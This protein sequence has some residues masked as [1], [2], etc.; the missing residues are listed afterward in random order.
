MKNTAFLFF[1]MIVVVSASA[2][3][4]TPQEVWIPMR[5][6]DSLAADLHAPQPEQP[7]PTILVQTPYNKYYFRFNLP[8]GYGTDIDECPYNFVIMDWR[9]FYASSEASNPDATRG[10]DGYDAIDWIK[11]QPWSD[12]NIGT[13]GAS[14]LGK[15][16]FMTANE[17]HPNHICAV[18]IVASPEYN[19]HVYYPNGVYRDEYMEQLD[20]LGFGISAWIDAHPYHDWLWT[21]VE[22]S[23]YAPEEIQ[24]PMLMI[25]GWYDHATEWVIRYF[26]GI[27]SQSPPGI[28]DQHK[29]MMG[30]WAHNTI[31]KLS[32]GELDFPAAE[33]LSEQYAQAFF[34]YHLLNAYNGWPYNPVVKYFQ[35]GDM[36]W[37]DTES[38][39]PSDF[40][41]DTFYLHGDGS[42]SANTLAAEDSCS[43]FSYD[44]RD[45]SPTI[46]GPTLHTDLQQGPYDQSPVVESRDDILIFDSGELDEPISV[47]GAPRVVLHVSSNRTDTDFAV[48]LTDVYPDGRSMILADGIYRMRFRNGY[49]STAESLITPG[50]IY[51]IE[52]ELPDMAQ[53]FPAGHH[54]RLDITSSNYPRFHRN[55]NNGEDLYAPGD[56]LAALN[57]VYHN[58]SNLSS[59]ILPVASSVNLTSEKKKAVN[60][61]PNPLPAGEKLTITGV[62]GETIS[63]YNTCGQLVKSVKLSNNKTYINLSEPGVYILKFKD[64]QT[65]CAETLFVY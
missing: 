29:L 7:R 57:K 9:G 61:Y 6:G 60:F 17:H 31:G 52:I 32:Q 37:Y 64:S 21:Y 19:Y 20:G 11:D 54:I 18:P 44:P 1:T 12:G 47:A 39:P 50:D 55:I 63:I 38:W 15:V 59:L 48:R 36:N 13:W 51:Q 62:S 41:D 42:M 2:Q 46:G 28:A 10:E 65:K 33:D 16:Q 22:D 49:T 56:T 53:T 3:P 8:V 23:T 40:I 14:A 4:L 35:M 34:E 26:N 58:A 5:D 24:I 43:T 25:G 27:R 45:P 30:P